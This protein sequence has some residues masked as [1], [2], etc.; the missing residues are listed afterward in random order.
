[1]PP[2]AAPSGLPI[3]LK[4]KPIF[5]DLLSIDKYN[6]GEYWNAHK[7]FCENFLN[8]LILTAKKG[9]NFNNWFRGNLEGIS[10]SELSSI[11]NL[12]EIINPT[13]FFH[14]YLLNKIENKAIKNPNFKTK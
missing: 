12:K 8:P 7:Q 14:V 11:L 1:M 3:I 4:G 9:I 5:I 6:E 10:T 2:R 13:I